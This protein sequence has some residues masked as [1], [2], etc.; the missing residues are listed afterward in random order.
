MVSLPD[1]YSQGRANI[2]V[3]SNDPDEVG[4]LFAMATDAAR[5]K[6]CDVIV[7]SNYYDAIASYY[8]SV[9]QAYQ[10]ASK[11]AEEII[12]RKHLQ[13]PPVMKRP[14]V[15]VM[16]ADD[17]SGIRAA[18]F[19]DVIRSDNNHTSKAAQIREPYKTKI[20]RFGAKNADYLP[21]DIKDPGALYNEVFSYSIGDQNS[22][23]A[24]ST[25]LAGKIASDIEQALAK[26]G[27]DRTMGH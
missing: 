21:D 4:K 23:Q 11:I 27:D 17:E 16:G 18:R 14:L 22:F 12:P 5:G 7:F 19:A 24:A 6:P 26:S 15:V 9:D 13:V 10:T 20:Y 1:K 3:V 25:K 2:Y 8:G